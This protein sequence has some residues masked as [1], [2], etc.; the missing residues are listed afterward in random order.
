MGPCMSLVSLLELVT[1]VVH[2]PFSLCVL[3]YHTSPNMPLSKSEA[4]GPIDYRRAL[5]DRVC[6]LV[7]EATGQRLSDGLM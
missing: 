6:S 4:T 2:A 1:S 7:M 3:S 5:Q